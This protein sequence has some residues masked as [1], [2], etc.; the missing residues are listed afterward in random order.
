M[1]IKQKLILAI[2]ACMLLLGG[3][4]AGLVEVASRR[5]VRFAAEQAV[6]AAA[7]GLGAMEKADVEKLDATLRVV[8]A[9]PGLVE[10]FRA[11]DRTRFMALASPIFQDLRRSHGVTL[12]YVHLPD[13]TNF[14]RV[15]KPALHGD[16]VERPTLAT[17][18]TSHGL[19]AGKELGAT[20][21][22]LR[23]VEPWVVEGETI[24]YLE[25]GEEIGHFLARLKLQ[26]GDDY[27]MLVAKRDAAGRPLVD[28]AAWAA[29]KAQQ[30]RPDDW[31][32]SAD[33]VVVDDTAQDPA[34]YQGAQVG[35]L[36]PGGL[37]LGEVE[38]GPRTFARGL[39]PVADARGSQVGGVVVLH[40]ITQLHDSML[41]ARS[42]ILITLVA[43]AILLT[44]VMLGLVQRLVFSRLDRMTTTLEDLGARLAGGEYDVGKLAPTGVKDE[45]GRFEEFFGGFLVVIGGLVKELTAR[46]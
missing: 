29:V 13:R 19:G 9:H 42:G 43:V 33:F 25:L 20:A 6:A 45:I 38:R 17:A 36:K 24:G 21:F 26:T 3:V 37:L 10:A 35:G 39:V 16:R 11:R 14:V 34:S 22:A 27:A 15:H 18:A 28:R 7:A 30:Q 46:R 8:A 31:D 23:A 4:T 5:A 40:D 12:F 1:S 44:L 32:A 2:A 41:R